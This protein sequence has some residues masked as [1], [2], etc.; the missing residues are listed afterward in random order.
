MTSPLGWPVESAIRVGARVG[1]NVATGCVRSAEADDAVVGISHRPL[2]AGDL[3]SP[4]FHRPETEFY[5]E[6]PETSNWDNPLDVLKFWT[7]FRQLQRRIYE[8]SKSKGFHDKDEPAGTYVRGLQ[9]SRSM[10][11]AVGELAEGH[12][13]FHRGHTPDQWWEEAD[14]KPEGPPI[15]IADTIIR[16]LDT[17]EAHGIDLVGAMVLKMAYNETRER[18]HGKDF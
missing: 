7:M 2:S 10:M 18:L 1:V 4:K 6:P 12:D 11:T 13:W 17:C 8:T 16:L 5:E 15:E 9:F 14:G 3:F